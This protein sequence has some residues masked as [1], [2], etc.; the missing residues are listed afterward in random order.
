M[1]W[2]AFLAANAF[3][4]DVVVPNFTATPGSSN[5]G[6]EIVYAAMLDAL[7]DRGLSVV[8]GD[9]LE[10][11][12]GPD[13]SACAEDPACPANIWPALRADLALLGTVTMNDNSVHAVIEFHRRGAADPVEVFEARFQAEVADRFAVDAALVTMDVLRLEPDALQV[14][15]AVAL[16][17]P[18][19][20][21]KDA[22]GT[23]EP[24]EPL[25]RPAAANTKRKM[26]PAPPRPPSA[27]GR[28]AQRPMRPDQERRY[29]GL[30][31]GLYDEF[32]ASGLSRS[33]F[34]GEKRYRA[35]TFYV[36]LAPGVVFGDVQRRYAVRT[37]LI[38]DG[39]GTFRSV[40]SY[41]RDQFLPSTAF[42]MVV[43]AGYAPAWWLDLGV[44][45]G[46]EFPRKELITGFEAYASKGDYDLGNLCDS[47]TDQ[48]VFQPATALTLL[49]EPRMRIV[50][51][52][53]GVVKPYLA[54]G[55]S[56]RFNDRY[57]TPDLEQ[58]AF[59][60]RPGV[61]SYGPFGGAGF[62]IDPR[63]RAGAFIEA[64]YT[65]LL[66]PGIMDVGRQYVQSIPEPMVGTGAV[67]AVRIG[68]VSRF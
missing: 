29:M 1:L 39:P 41:E 61:Q 48:T 25:P 45:V 58:V 6:P 68:A 2:I 65:H 24:V 37:A 3:A 50:L 42:S 15:G 19:T 12:V 38:E 16:T 36:E 47:C 57:Q 51:A 53:T 7:A 5:A 20:V 52:P 43:A 54:A 56:T 35:R 11:L 9:D 49:V 30:S 21:T 31:K 23:I 33:E 59:R 60:D 28:I 22:L 46:M 34:L 66:G 8:D 26:V 40:G 4:T 13:A 18:A 67:M 27:P 62:G 32:R 44:S 14:A 10:R 63:R 17:G 64:T 55:W